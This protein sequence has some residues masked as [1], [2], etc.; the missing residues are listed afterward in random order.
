MPLRELA[1][2]FP[3]QVSHMTVKRIVDMA[4][5]PFVVLQTRKKPWLRSTSPPKRLQF[6][7]SQNQKKGEWWQHVVFHDETTYVYEPHPARDYVHIRQSELNQSILSTKLLRPTF[8]SGRTPIL[9][10]AAVAYGFKS[11]LVWVQRRTEEERRRPKDRLGLDAHQFAEEIHAP[12][13]IPFCK[14]VAGL[15]GISLHSVQV[16][17]DNAGWHKGA[18]NRAL[19]KEAGYQLVPWPP[20]SPDLN[21]IENVWNIWKGR[22]RKRFSRLE[23]LGVSLEGD[24][25]FGEDGTF[26]RTYTEDELWAAGLEEW[27][28]IEQDKIDELVRTMPQRIKAVIKANGGHTKW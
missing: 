12:Y 4:D 5:D 3:L 6:A 18:Q 27:D 2:Q 16:V 20:Q 19:Q 8:Q 22:L 9:V 25:A 17:G 7:H 11:Q 26:G 14:T 24:G 10:W 21:V 28:A 15:N 1:T 23:N 13:L